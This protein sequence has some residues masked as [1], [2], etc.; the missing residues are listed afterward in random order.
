MLTQHQLNQTLKK[1]LTPELLEK[2]KVKDPFLPNG[3]QISGS[4]KIEKIVTGVSISEEFINKAVEKNAQAMIFHHGLQLE[5]P[6]HVMRADHKKRLQLI[7]KNDLNVYGYHFVLDAHPTL[8]NNAQ[9]AQKLNAEIIESYFDEWGY[10][11]K[12]QKSTTNKQ[13]SDKLRKIFD[14]DIF[15]V[16]GKEEIQTLGIVSGGG[17]PGN[18]ELITEIVEKNVDAHITGEIKERIPHQFKELDISY[19]AG[20]HYATE[21]L[22]IKALTEELKKELQGK[23]EVEFVDVENEL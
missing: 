17:I 12:L 6:Y 3:L 11:A 9:L 21:T 8:G 1:I 4:E 16:K 2:A 13:L 20:G 14:H 18:K 5:F 22:G 7:F 19:F 23:I 10:V 15:I